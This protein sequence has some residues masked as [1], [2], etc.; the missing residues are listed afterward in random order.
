M[1]L[2]RALGVLV[3]AG[4]YLPLHLLLDPAVTGIAGRATR[5]VA[6]VAWMAGI[7]GTFFVAVTAAL[8][9]WLLPAEPLGSLAD[10][11]GAAVER[12]RAGVFAAVA[13]TITFLL[14]AGFAHFYLHDLPSS[15][16]EMVQL[17]H[18]RAILAGHTALPLPG[19]A[20]AWMVQNSIPTPHGLA[21][22]YP[23]MHTLALALGLAVGASWLVGPA[24][25]GVAVGF[26]AL[27]FERALPD[28]RTARI[29]GALNALCPFVIFLGG[30]HLS[31]TTALAFAALTAW[32]ALR[33]R[34]GHAGWAAV[35][36]AATGAFVC[37]RPWTG[38]VLAGLILA[39]VWLPHVRRRSKGWVL[40]RGGLLVL[41]GIP[42]AVFL[43]WWN[44]HL[45]GGPLALGY[46]AAFGPAQGL[47]FRI[48]PWGNVYGPLQALAYTGADLVQLG[49]HLLESPLPAL[50]L[51]GVGLLYA[52][53]LPSGS[54]LLMAWAFGAVAANAVY[55]H[56]GFH[57]GP[58]FLYESAPGWVGLWVVS[59]VTLA[60]EGREL[61]SAPRRAV[62]WA[63]TLSLLGGALLV[64]GRAASYRIGPEE[65]SAETLPHVP[66]PGP[67]LVFVHGSWSSRIS[68]RLVAHGMRR[69][70]VETALRRNDVCA[71]D[72][73]A[74][75]RA[76]GE[77]GSPPALALQRLPGSPP[78]LVRRLLSPGN[79]IRMEP[80][81]PAD[82]TCVREA[83]ADRFGTI[84]LEPLL[85]QA[86][87][88]AG[89]RLVLARDLG[90]ITDDAVR[91][92][93]PG[94]TA[95]VYI[96]R[97]ARGAPRLL[98]YREGIRLVWGTGG[99]EA[100][101]TPK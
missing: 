70:S 42:F 53:R 80:N 2:R 57:M 40:A 94:R 90:P 43:F 50:A 20:A 64:S 84:E 79:V 14:S 28:L 29:A 82:S 6:G 58:R 47:G 41:G 54:G 24:M 39:T 30:T 67:A 46:T 87:P 66:G 100:G 7:E 27:V 71:V 98:P 37:T 63:A 26:S 68:A 13:G 22:I 96:A 48:D 44:N 75:W 97:G 85:W 74:R 62:V 9:A 78:D 49:T 1:K 45:F 4:T 59:V 18:A 77:H 73:Y 15:V 89:A 12:P 69:D 61:A 33:A 35:A 5:S 92:A 76:T 32:T 86:P 19:P 8:L 91:K 56:H 38:T 23:P 93:L 17:L 60:R 81:R 10:R 65:R 83:R 88:L 95:W 55:W 36:G 21:S 72:Q 31:H 99:E 25:A 16:D 101:S 11:V 51:V 52:R 3:L 34:D